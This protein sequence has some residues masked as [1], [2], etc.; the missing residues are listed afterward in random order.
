MRFYL[1]E[2]K[3]EREY[4]REGGKPKSIF[5]LVGRECS[6]ISRC[7]LVILMLHDVF[8][9]FRCAVLSVCLV[10]IQDVTAYK[11]SQ[12]GWSGHV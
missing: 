3:K 10:D 5:F 4:S 9:V 6:R 7:C 8:F 2:R 12:F 1:I 11:S